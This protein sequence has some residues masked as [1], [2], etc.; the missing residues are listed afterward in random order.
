MK[1]CKAKQ[2]KMCSAYESVVKDFQTNLAS[3]VNVSSSLLRDFGFNFNDSNTFQASQ[4][5]AI[6]TQNL[7]KIMGNVDPNQSLVSKSVPA[8]I[9][10]GQ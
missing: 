4:T 7:A 8:L 10:W 1:F 5:L 2:I 9:D 6:C 3:F